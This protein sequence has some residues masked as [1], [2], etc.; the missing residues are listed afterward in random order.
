MTLVVR[1]MTGSL[2]GVKSALRKADTGVGNRAIML[3]AV[4]PR[5]ATADE[6]H[7]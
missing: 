5:F 7:G 2:R 3:S 4:A 1:R 6:S